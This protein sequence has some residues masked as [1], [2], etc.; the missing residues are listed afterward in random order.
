MNAAKRQELAE[1]RGP[2]LTLVDEL[3]GCSSC[4]CLLAQAATET[5]FEDLVYLLLSTV[6]RHRKYHT[7]SYKI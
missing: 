2:L 3:R 6:A 5:S 1:E 7:T 4:S